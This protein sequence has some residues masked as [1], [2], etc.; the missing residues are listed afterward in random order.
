MRIRTFALG[1]NMLWMIGGLALLYLA[2]AFSRFFVIPLLGL[3]VFVGL[4]FMAI[5]CPRCGRNVYRKKWGGPRL[6]RTISH[7]DEY[8]SG[9][10][11]KRCLNCGMDLKKAKFEWRMLSSKWKPTDAH[12]QPGISPP[13]T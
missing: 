9:T 8:I 3:F 12:Q 10:M 4:S 7:G 13:N 1:L 11:A 6:P 5:R 2:G